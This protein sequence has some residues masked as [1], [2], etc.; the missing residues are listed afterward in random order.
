MFKDVLAIAAEDIAAIQRARQ[1]GHS[2]YDADFVKK[3]ETPPIA[4]TEHVD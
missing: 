1:A 4:C 3:S 2:I